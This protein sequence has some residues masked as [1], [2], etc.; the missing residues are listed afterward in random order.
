MKNLI[1]VCLSFAIAATSCRSLTSNTTIK[2]KDS[3]VLG[4]NEHDAFKVKLKN[5]SATNLTVYL[6][7]IEGGTHSPQVVKPSQSVSVKVAKNTALVVSNN[8]NQTTSV[9]LKVE[10]DTHLSM[11]YKN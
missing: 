2:P 8:S 7:P 10:G 1:I 9:D 3:F 4:N 6:A 5:V 11:G